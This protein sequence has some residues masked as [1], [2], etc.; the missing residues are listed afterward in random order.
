MPLIQ[1][2]DA[3]G[4]YSSHCLSAYEGGWEIWESS[5]GVWILEEGEH[6]AR[7]EYPTLDSAIKEVLTHT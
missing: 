6:A 1:Y 7:S 5:P 2:D 4:V 3:T